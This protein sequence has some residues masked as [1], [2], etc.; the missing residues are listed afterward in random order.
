MT[1]GFLAIVLYFYY[2]YIEWL[3]LDLVL[4]KQYMFSFLLYLLTC[5]ISYGNVYTNN[6]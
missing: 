5:S 1:K 3:L 2:I 6:D 4:L